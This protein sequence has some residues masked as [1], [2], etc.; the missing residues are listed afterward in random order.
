MIRSVSIATAFAL[1]VTTAATAQLPEALRDVGIDQHLN[2]SV[3]LDL[4]FRDESGAS[5]RLGDYFGEKPVILALVYYECPMLCTLVLNGLVSS[6]KALSFS[7]GD[8]FDV[9]TLS[10]DPKET[11][12]MAAA[13][14]KTYLDTYRRPSAAEG[15]HFLTGDEESIRRLADAVG[16]RYRYDPESDE[17]AH[18]AGITV[19]TPQ[20]RDCTLLLRRR[21]RAARR[22]PRPDRSRGRE[23]RLSG[24][25]TDALLLPIRRNNRAL[26]RGRAEPCSPRR[27]SH[28]AGLRRFRSHDPDSPTEVRNARAL[29][30]QIDRNA[31][32]FPSFPKAPRRGRD[33]STRSSFS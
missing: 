25:P 20:R 8:E 23:D 4:T 33:R 18:A 29:L 6:L 10:F 2:Q 24:R 28:R 22:S 16:F 11:P 19:L 31:Y 30:G 13:K 12:E 5:V 3:P 15:W 17:F 7:I 27:H 9:V 32:A 1:L 14:K 26:Q 21:V